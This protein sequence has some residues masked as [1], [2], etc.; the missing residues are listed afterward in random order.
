MSKTK[1]PFKKL[2]KTRLTENEKIKGFILRNS[3]R[4][5]FTRIP[6]IAYKF[7]ITHAKAWNIVGELLADDSI[8]AHHDNNGEMKVCETGQIFKILNKTKKK[9]N[10]KRNQ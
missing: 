3:Q 2:K 4:G 8:E 6:T 5:Y 10:F 9:I 1:K 7:E